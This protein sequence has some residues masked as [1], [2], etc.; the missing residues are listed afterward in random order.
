[1]T[2]T[3]REQVI[4]ELTEHVFSELCGIGSPQT[5]NVKC[6]LGAAYDLGYRAGVEAA[7]QVAEGEAVR[8]LIYGGEQCKIVAA[9]IRALAE[10][11]E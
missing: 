1:M 8:G 4:A 5:H 2:E 6:W 10:P 9:A 3:K 11:R 7:A